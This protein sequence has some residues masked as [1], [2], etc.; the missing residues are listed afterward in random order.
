MIDSISLDGFWDWQ[1]PG[2]AWQRRWVPSSYHCVG[3]ARYRTQAALRLAPGK[4]AFLCFDGIAYQGRAWFNGTALGDML[5]Y[6]PYRF[7]VTGCARDGANQVE[8]EVCDIAAGYGPTGGWEDYG[9]ITRSVRLE[10]SDPVRIDDLHWQ[11]AFDDGYTAARCRLDV[12]LDAGGTAG[13]ARLAMTLALNG[14]PVYRGEQAADLAAGPAA[15]EFRVENPLLWSPDSP[16]LYD[17]EVVL[18]AGGF[19]DTRAQRAGFREFKAVGSRFV[20]NGKETFLKGVARHEMWGEHQGF[21]LSRAQIERDI[22]LIKGMG[23]NFVRLVHYP[24]SRATLELC[25]ELGVMATEEPGLWWSNLADPAMATNALA[26]LE[27]T[28]LR[29]RNSPSLVAWLL[30]NEC[31]FDGADDYLSRGRALCNRLDP[32][33]L[34]SA[35]NCLD[36]AEAKALFDRTG[37]DFY[38]F[39]PYAYEP[40]LMIQGL[41]ALQG[42][43]CVFTEW[44]GWLIMGNPNLQR[45]FGRTIVEYAHN[46]APRP[47]LAGMAWWQFQDVFQFSRGLPGCV[48]GTLTDGL[49]DKERNKKP[50]YDVMADYFA[51]IDTPRQPEYRLE[52]SGQPITGD[53]S[54]I[55]AAVDLSP[56]QDSAGQ[57]AAWDSALSELR[58]FQAGD[59]API[60]RQ[61]GPIL[62]HPVENVGGLRTR[63]LGRPLILSAGCRRL[64]IACG[65]AARKVYFLGQTTFYDGYPVRGRLGEVIARYTLRYRDGRRTDVDLRNGY[66]MVSASMIH[67][68]SRI[69]PAAAHTRRALVLHLEE[70][71]EVYQVGCLE[72]ETAG[73]TIDAIE[74]TSLSDDFCPLLYGISAW[75]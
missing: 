74:F 35:A 48:D 40:H 39:H 58:V 10:V 52:V 53:E 12:A 17:I 15:F 59:P 24:H 69:D 18:E 11:A 65:F 36:P 47:N 43:P 33:K 71:W 34:V 31:K 51:A 23:G 32:G 20:L 9:G 50:M 68:T 25:D 16:V 2:G 55:T 6:V 13:E 46:R 8:V 4:R 44:G 57:K 14:R 72:V 27:R 66:E 45:W 21:T 1:A 22:R 60:R 41:E 62:L 30:F 42:K 3:T 26:V 38:T 75:V 29:D 5:P 73:A 56:Y 49:V 61:T 70:D 19:R 28:I 67:R 7:E 64:D 54:G 37:M 63:L